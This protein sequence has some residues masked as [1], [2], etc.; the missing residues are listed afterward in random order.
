MPA[1]THVLVH[2]YM[3]IIMHMSGSP[4]CLALRTGGGRPASILLYIHTIVKRVCHT[5]GQQGAGR[6]VCLSASAS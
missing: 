5:S 2:M 4:R 3:Y 6:F 1:Q